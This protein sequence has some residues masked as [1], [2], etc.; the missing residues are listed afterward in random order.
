M[1]NPTS[2]VG[3]KM[4]NRPTNFPTNFPTNSLTNS[5]TPTK[6]RKKYSSP[7]TGGKNTAYPPARLGG[8]GRVPP[9]QPAAT[10]PDT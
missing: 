6:E 4:T 10:M 3:Q 9:E 7:L 2:K 1:T 8:G 5:L